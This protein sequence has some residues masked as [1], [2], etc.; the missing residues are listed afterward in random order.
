[1]TSFSTHLH[2]F[3]GA[4]TSTQGRRRNVALA[5][6]P[7]RIRLNC[8]LERLLLIA[9]WTRVIQRGTRDD[10]ISDNGAKNNN[11]SLCT[12]QTRA[13]TAPKPK[14]PWLD[15]SAVK[16]ALHDV[17]WPERTGKCR[18]QVALILG[19]G[20]RQAFRTLAPTAPHSTQPCQSR[21]RTRFAYVH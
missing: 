10:A 9:T 16:R 15:Q 5:T 13:Q 2:T 7:V 1:M 19:R 4:D 12:Q 21:C 14:D 17:I 18:C 11:I 3:L 20:W 6:T 8:V